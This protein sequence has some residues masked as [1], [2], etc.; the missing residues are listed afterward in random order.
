MADAGE[1]VRGR[2]RTAVPRAPV[3]SLVP[4]V[5]VADV[6]RSA[7]FYALLGLERRDSFVQ[8]GWL[9]WCHL[10]NEEAQ[11]MLAL[12]GEPIEPEQQAVLFY[13]YTPDLRALRTSLIES[14]VNPGPIE[15]GSPGPAREM[16][17]EDPDGYVLMVAEAA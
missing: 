11:L 6:E 15:D 10:A 7:A 5:H 16:R 3:T 9:L 12:A 4:F 1:D 8:D 13:L 17:L 14:G 2:Y